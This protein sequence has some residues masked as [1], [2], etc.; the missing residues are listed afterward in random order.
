MEPLVSVIIVN[1]NGRHYLRDCFEALR[2]GTYRNVEFILVDNGSADGS[3]AFMAEYYPEVRLVDNME[4]LG[5]AIASNRGAAIASG[6]Y[7]FFFN[8]DTKADSRM[9]SELVRVAESDR[10][11]GICGCTTL[12][13][14]G[15]EVINSGVACDIYGYPYGEGEPLYVDA[16]IFIRKEVF[17]EIGGFDPKLFLYGEDRD[18]CWRA[19]LY[20][21]DVV[22]VPTAFF[23]HDSFC[24]VKGGKLVTNVWKRHVGERNLIRSLLKNYSAMT[25]AVI[26]PRYLMLSLSEMILF[27]LLGR[28]HVVWGAYLKAYLWNIWNIAETFSMRRRIQRERRRPD[29]FIMKRMGKKSGKLE[30]F[31]KKGI[32]R[33]ASSNRSV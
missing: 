11:I 19:L 17:D 31:K 1:Y 27:S 32:P 28:F 12:T 10:S 33:F 2:S 13:Y 15:S 3:L 7:L 26:F 9:L 16:A 18:I 21:Y 4:N 23:M 8:N 14:D 29:A 25:L 24:S 5:L 6:K 30:L 20:G 22:V